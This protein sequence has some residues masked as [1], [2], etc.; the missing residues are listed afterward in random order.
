MIA[1][2]VCAIL[3][4]L[5]VEGDIRNGLMMMKYAVN[6]RK[7]FRSPGRAYSIGFM[8]FVGG[9]G[10]ELACVSFLCTQTDTI[11]TLTKFIA[12]AFISKVDDFYAAALPPAHILN[13]PT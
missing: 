6:H 12:L 11:R 7:A 2:F 10:A 4:H 5:Q 8:Q 9:L 3:M 13:A 1:R